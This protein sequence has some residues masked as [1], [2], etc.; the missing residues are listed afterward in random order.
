MRAAAALSE[1]PLPAHAVG[2]VVGEVMERLSGPVDLLC[3]FVGAGLTGAIEDIS[4]SLR[5]L[6]QPAAMIGST[7][8]GV[9]SQVSEV[10]HRPA[11]SIWAATGIS[12]STFRIEAGEFEPMRGWDSL[13]AKTAVLLTDPF[14]V[15]Q[16]ELLT[17]VGETAPDLLLH[18]GLASAANGPGGNRL[19]LDGAVHDD[20]AVGV[21]LDGVPMTSVVSQGCRPVGDAFTVT[22]VERNIVTSLGS[23][24]PLERLQSIADDA[25]DAERALLGAGVHIG[26]VMDEQQDEFVR[27][28]FLI[29]AVMGADRESGALAI[30]AE[31]PIGTTVQF[32]VRDAATASEDLRLMLAE[33]EAVAALTFTCNGRGAHLFGESGHDAENVHLLTGSGA[34]AGMFCAG[35]LGPIGGTNQLHGFT[36]STLLFG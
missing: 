17:R 30:G 8:C 26:I 13:T 25:D 36:A 3:V 5:E 4:N 18:G 15:P 1:H 29:R 33:H 32:Q 10:E 16:M 20:G 34:T 21:A 28:D 14:T 35:E 31:V 24:S 7:A 6:L 9:L 23:Q 2:E 12:A 11:L 27:G 22:G 19:L